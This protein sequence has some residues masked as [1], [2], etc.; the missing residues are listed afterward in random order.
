[1]QLVVVLERLQQTVLDGVLRLFPDKAARHR[2]QPR[3]LL[4]G[5]PLEVL[6][7]FGRKPHRRLPRLGTVGSHAC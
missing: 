1:M 2:V 7:L 5:Q 6:D 3:D 4:P